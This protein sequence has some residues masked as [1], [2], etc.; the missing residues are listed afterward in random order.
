MITKPLILL[1]T[2][3]LL[4]SSS[5]I[6]QNKK[7]SQQETQRWLNEKLTELSYN[8]DGAKY[9]YTIAFSN[10]IMTIEDN[11][12]FSEPLRSHKNIHS[13]NLSDID[14]FVFKEKQNNI[15]LTFKMKQ[16]K[17]ETNIM[18]GERFRSFGEINILLSKAI[19]NGNL[20]QRVTNAINRIFELN[21]ISQKDGEVF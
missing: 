9:N 10:G 18:D 11:N 19:K 21:G 13:C 17:Y 16:G 4:A 20:I 7:P 8:S 1:L 6:A 5:T 2:I 12:I 3:V 15:W 14:S